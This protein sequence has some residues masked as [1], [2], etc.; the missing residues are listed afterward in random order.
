MENV[1]HRLQA[2]FG[3]RARVELTADG[4]HYVTTLSYPLTW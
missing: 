4:D 3:P 2:H 1:R